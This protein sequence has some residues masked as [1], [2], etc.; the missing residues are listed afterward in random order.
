[1]TLQEILNICAASS[2]SDWHQITCWGARSGPSYLDHFQAVKTHSGV[3]LRHDQHGMRATYTPDINIGLAWGIDPDNMWPDERKTFTE[4]WSEGF[5]DPHW[6]WGIADVLHC[7]NL[8]YRQ[9]YVTVD[10]ARCHLPLPA[11]P[12]LTVDQL[13]HDLVR[14][15]DLFEGG[16][17]FDRYFRDAGF[18]ISD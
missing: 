12:D 2:P 17:E 4:S 14:L 6:T 9:N 13:S 18:K 1:M 7:G 3:E 8:V 11:R 16:N 5:S 15:I 10:G